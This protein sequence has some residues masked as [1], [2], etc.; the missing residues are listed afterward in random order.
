LCA[1]AFLLLVLLFR[2]GS[3]LLGIRFMAGRLRAA[4]RRRLRGAAELV[5]G[6]GE[7]LARGD[8]IG[9]A[10]R[11]LADGERA[12][13]QRLGFSVLVLRLIQIGERVQRRGNVR[14][15]RSLFLGQRQRLLGERHGLRVFAGRLQLGDLPVERCYIA[16]RTP[17][18]RLL[19][20]GILGLAV[21]LPRRPALLCA[22]DI[23][24]EDG[25]Q[26]EN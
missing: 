5:V 12:F 22:G 10:G 7:A 14:A 17:P 4:Q 18:T 20:R 15:V 9:L 1:C 2:F 6:G 25:K 16:S 23:V 3:F 8:D 21:A 26:R 19:A 13:Q 24:E 11:L